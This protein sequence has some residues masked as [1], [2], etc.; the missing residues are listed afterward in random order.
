MFQGSLTSDLTGDVVILGPGDTVIDEGDGRVRISESRKT[1]NAYERTV[2]FS[3]LS[4]AD[5]G[6][7]RCTGTISPVAPNPL[8]TNG[9]GNEDVLP[10]TVSGEFL[11]CYCR[12]K[13]NDVSTLCRAYS[14]CKCVTRDSTPARHFSL[15]L[16]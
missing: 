8:V 5:I 3:P 10:I 1:T 13:D 11:V 15:Q 9:M 16:R 4:A 12:K 2:F 6:D 7:Y 14:E